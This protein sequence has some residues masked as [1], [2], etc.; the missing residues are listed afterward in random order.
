MSFFPRRAEFSGLLPQIALL[1]LARL[2]SAWQFPPL[3]E[4][5]DLIEVTNRRPD[6]H[7]QGHVLLPMVGMSSFLFPFPQTHVA[8]TLEDD[9]AVRSR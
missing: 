3:R 6:S 9:E 8:K 1:L 2:P 5:N 7:V 4:T